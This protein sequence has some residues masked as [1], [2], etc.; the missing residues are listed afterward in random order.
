MEN[1]LMHFGVK[2]MKGGERMENELM[3]FGVKGMKWGVRRHR[4]PDG[5]LT[6]A[7]K[8]KNTKKS[9]KVD[10]KI[11]RDLELKAYD[12]AR[13]TNAYSKK[14]KTYSK[15]YERAIA[16]DPTKSTSKTQRIE[17]TKKLLDVNVK[18]W[19]NYNSENV[20]Q[21]KKQV[22][23]MIDKY[24]DTRIKDINVKTTKNGI[25]YV[26]SILATMYNSNVTYDLRKRTNR[27]YNTNIYMPVK[28]RHYYY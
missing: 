10:K 14:L 8:K 25:E 4:N 12:S 20:R 3:H 16:K 24:S 7:G 11:R 26:N 1:E 17:N 13:F 18:S 5:S 28:T 27:Q 2:G 19:N 9:L 22:N 23:R 6:S 21:L 15:K